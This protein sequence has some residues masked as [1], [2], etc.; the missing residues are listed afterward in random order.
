M[1]LHQLRYF[2]AVAERLHFAEAAESVHVS[3]PGLSQQI[4]AL[5]E[6]VGVLLLERTK[7]TVALTEAVDDHVKA[8]A[9][10][11]GRFRGGANGRETERDHRP[12][13]WRIRYSNSAGVAS[14]YACPIGCVSPAGGHSAGI[15]TRCRL[16]A[17]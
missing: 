9:K 8:I 7:R 12:S 4:K 17:R 13:R 16:P 3:Q 11:G 2:V 6:E 10:R 1:D 5:E 14:L 15:G